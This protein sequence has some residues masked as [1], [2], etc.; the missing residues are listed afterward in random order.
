[1]CMPACG[2]IEPNGVC[3]VSLRFTPLD[4]TKVR[5]TFDVYG[6]YRDENDPLPATTFSVE[7]KGEK[8]CIVSNCGLPRALDQKERYHKAGQSTLNFVSE[9]DIFIGCETHGFSR[10]FVMRPTAGGLTTSSGLR[11]FGILQIS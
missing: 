11:L 6:L 3:L 2:V 7:G 8:P 9:D 5:E 1:M 4:F 10:E